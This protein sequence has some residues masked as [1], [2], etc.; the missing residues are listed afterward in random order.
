[1]LGVEGVP[2]GAAL[3]AAARDGSL[4][5]RLIRVAATPG[6]AC[7]LPS[8]L[9]HALGAGSLVLEVQTPSDTTLRLHDWT[10]LYG[11]APRAMHV[12]AGVEAARLDAQPVWGRKIADGESGSILAIRDFELGVITG[13]SSGS[14]ARV[15][16]VMPSARCILVIPLGK[17]AVLRGPWGQ[18]E[19]PAHRVT[20]VPA[21]LGACDLE[22]ADGG[23]AF[24]VRVLGG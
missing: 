4:P 20:I 23:R 9:V 5:A 11:R 7:W 10:G 24:V 22:V 13:P 2:D 3:A 1:M 12:E 19:A 8:G 21:S 17:R 6:T 15:L 18:V 16:S 14:V